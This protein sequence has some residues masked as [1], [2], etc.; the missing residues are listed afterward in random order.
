MS[1]GRSPANELYGLYLEQESIV[2]AYFV[3]TCTYEHISETP[4]ERIE[5][6][7]FCLKPEGISLPNPFRTQSIKLS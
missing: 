6:V 5:S 1:P 2:S 7:E 4:R 3:K